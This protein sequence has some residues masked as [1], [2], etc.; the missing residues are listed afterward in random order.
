MFS[1]AFIGSAAKTGIINVI[2]ITVAAEQLVE[3]LKKKKSFSE[4]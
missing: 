2:I 3:V 1:G 4:H